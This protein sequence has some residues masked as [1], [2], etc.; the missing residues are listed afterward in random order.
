MGLSSEV[1][2]IYTAF[3]LEDY[4]R[5]TVIFSDTKER[6]HAYCKKI[7]TVGEYVCLYDVVLNIIDIL[8]HLNECDYAGNS[9]FTPALDIGYIYY[10]AVDKIIVHPQNGESSYV[11][12]EKAS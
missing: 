6:R 1:V 3:N 10:D 9:I 4:L 12:F 8:P 2:E 7:S 5:I 11:L